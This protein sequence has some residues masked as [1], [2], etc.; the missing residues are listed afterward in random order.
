MP[1]GEMPPATTK[2]G[3]RA[4][5]AADRSV[6]AGK[7]SRAGGESWQAE[8]SSKTRALILDA[9]MRSLVKYGYAE[10]KTERIAKLAGVS[11]GAMTHH[12]RSRAALFKAIARYIIELRASEFDV[13]M[14]DIHVPAGELPKQEDMRKTIVVLRRYYAAP[15]FIALDELLRGART[16]TALT[17]VLVPLEREL[18][19]KI[20]DT[21]LRRFPFWAAVSGAREVLTDLVTFTLQGVAVNPAAYVEKDRMGHLIDLLAAIVTQEFEAAYRSSQASRKAVEA[22]ASRRSAD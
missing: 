11:R 15:S 10:T 18:D 8:K 22:A 1:R 12:F 7:R 3:A 6:T 9:G 4:R 14:E 13:L 21:M 20:A 5:K 2:L 19:K 17:R 16:D